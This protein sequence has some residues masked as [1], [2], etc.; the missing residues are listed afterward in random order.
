M[1]NIKHSFRVICFRKLW[2]V[3]QNLVDINTVFLITVILNTYWLCARH[4][5]IHYHHHQKNNTSKMQKRQRI[6]RQESE[7]HQR[8][9]SQEHKA[10]RRPITTHKNIKLARSSARL[11]CLAC[12][13]TA[14]R[15]AAIA[16]DSS[17]SSVGWNQC[18]SFIWYLFY[19][20]SSVAFIP[21]FPSHRQIRHTH[22]LTEVRDQSDFDRTKSCWEHLHRKRL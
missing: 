8:I 3:S 5:I 21:Q 14:K 7:N 16:L 6:K 18:H 20:S 12:T 10:H 9:S 13:K 4:D 19:S 22:S 1:D 17:K 15:E 2:K 11:P